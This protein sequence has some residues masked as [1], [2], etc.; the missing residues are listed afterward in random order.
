MILGESKL[1]KKASLVDLFSLKCNW[2][3][4]SD[5]DLKS[6]TSLF[7]WRD[8]EASSYGKVQQRL[9]AFDQGRIPLPRSKQAGRTIEAGIIEGRWSRSR[10]PHAG[11]L[12]QS[13]REWIDKRRGIRVYFKILHLRFFLACMKSIFFCSGVTNLQANKRLQQSV[14]HV[15][16]CLAIKRVTWRAPGCICRRKHG[17]SLNAKYFLF[18]PFKSLHILAHFYP[19]VL[20]AQANVRFKTHVHIF[21]HMRSCGR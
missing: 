1:I 10:S 21:S 7:L 15:I 20:G 18:L 4:I 2:M 9:T 8:W 3:N 17:S 11:S 14:V 6:L 5:E 19:R 16:A 13:S 12:G